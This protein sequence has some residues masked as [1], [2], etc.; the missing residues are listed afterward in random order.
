MVFRVIV[1]IAVIVQALRISDC[2][3]AYLDSQL[4]GKLISLTSQENFGE[5]AFSCC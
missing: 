3:A 1:V 5:L 4:H 2:V